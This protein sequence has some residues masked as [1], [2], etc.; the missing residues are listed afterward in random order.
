MSTLLYFAY[1]SN[2][3]ERRLRARLPG[4]R[5]V[6]QARLPNHALRFHK[7]SHRDGTGKC[8]IVAEP[9]SCVHGVLF[10]IGQSEKSALDAI[11]GVGAGYDATVREVVTAEGRRMR[12]HTYVATLTRDD[13][14]PLHWYR[15]HVLTGARDAGLPAE[16]IALIEAIDA[17]E[18][19]DPERTGKEM[20]VYD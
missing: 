13:L 12:A 11:E 14:R 19:P 16:Y 3:S 18:D 2:M 5:L 8:D 9:G 17:D 20:S 15:H 1:G 7:L 10:E 4:A 6:G